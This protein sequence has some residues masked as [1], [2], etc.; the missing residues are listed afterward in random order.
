[1]FPG[2][3]FDGAAG[4]DQAVTSL[5]TK[6]RNAL[7]DNTVVEERSH[8]GLVVVDGDTTLFGMIFTL[9]IELSEGERDFNITRGVAEGICGVGGNA[10]VSLLVVHIGLFV[11]SVNGEGTKHLQWSIFLPLHE[12]QVSS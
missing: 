2:D 11:D 10:K 3:K 12:H 7:A 6:Q 8:A 4:F 9:I 1:M 5:I